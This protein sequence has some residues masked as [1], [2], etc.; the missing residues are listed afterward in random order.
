MTPEIWL[1]LALVTTVN[2]VLWLVKRGSAQNDRAYND[3]R[4]D[5]ETARVAE[6]G[7]IRT[8]AE[9]ATLIAQQATQVATQATQ[10]TMLTR[11]V[12]EVS[13]REKACTVRAERADGLIATLRSEV[14]EMRRVMTTD[15]GVPT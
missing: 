7:F 1:V 2:G 10:I 8:I 12:F 11:E 3:A 6:M 15:R 13:E 4:T 9:Q 5:I 14:D